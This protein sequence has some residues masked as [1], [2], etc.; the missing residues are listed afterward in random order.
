MKYLTII[1]PAYNVSEYIDACL[2]SLVRDTELLKDLDIIAVN[3]GSKDDTL[4]KM[5]RYSDRYPESIRVIDK[6]NGG[7]G[8]GIN[9]GIELAC[10]VYLKV[11]DSDDWVD[12][13]GLKTLVERIRTAEEKPD[14]ILNPYHF[15]W[16]TDGHRE[17]SDYPKLPTDRL[18]SLKDLNENRYD[19]TIHSLT[20][21][22]DIYKDNPIPQIDEKISYDDMEYI[23]YPVP[24]IKKVLYMPDVVYEYRFGME[25]QSVSLQ[26]FVKRR[27]QHKKVILSLMHY[28]QDNVALFSDEQKTYYLNRVSDMISLQ[29][30]LFLA[31]ED[32]AEGKKEMI[33]FMEDCG[34]FEW[35]EVKG[36]KVKFLLKHNGRGFG[37][38]KRLFAAKKSIGF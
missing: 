10:G 36:K 23:L 9:K 25:G 16:Q 2:G 37:I 28:Y 20:I 3:D 13:Q 21:R 19:F 5:L 38:I 34:R 1:I 18:L 4:E 35:A 29:A 15:V 24:Y 14:I 32:T 27:D 7:H 31:M 8:S 30:E 12:E 17:L 22:T 26:N 11:L 33:R 6:E